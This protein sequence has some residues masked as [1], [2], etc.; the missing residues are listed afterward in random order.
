M[1]RT[2]DHVA[3]FEPNSGIGELTD[4]E[5]QT[6]DNGNEAEQTAS[7]L[8]QDGDYLRGA[9]YGKNVSVSMEYAARSKASGPYTV[10][11][12]GQRLREANDKPYVHIDNLSVRYGNNSIP[13]LSVGG[14][15]HLDGTVASGTTDYGHDACREYAVS[16]ELAAMEI[17]CPDKLVNVGETFD[18]D[19][20]TTFAFALAADAAVDIRSMSYSA[21]VNH[22][23]E[24]TRT[25]GHLRGDN[26]DGTETVTVE[27]T[28]LAVL[29]SDF[30][31][32]TGW[33]LDNKGRSRSNTAFSSTSITLTHHVA[34]IVAQAGNS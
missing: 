7:A 13:T 27:F 17:G 33:T 15:S 23:D 34:H 8:K 5:L 9:Q 26:Y 4:W 6:G 1:S 28:G 11:H 22:V 12:V 14:H 3:A 24:P 30:L 16:V 20:P 29:G 18:E 2:T 19:D 10:P 32:G 31:V 25:G 21:Q